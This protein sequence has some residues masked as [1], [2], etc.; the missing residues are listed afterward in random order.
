MT[1]SLQALRQHEMD[2]WVRSQRHPTLPLTIWNY[3]PSCQFQAHWNDVTLAC[4][5]LVTDD[6]GEIVARPVS[7]FFN[8]QEPQSASIIDYSAGFD[9]FT[10]LDGCLCV[11]FNYQGHWVFASRGSF[12]SDHA[13]RMLQ[14][15]MQDHGHFDMLDPALTYCF[16]LIDPE[17]RIVVDYGATSQLVL[18][19]AFDTQT[20][21]E[22]FDILEQMSDIL[23][24]VQR[25]DGLSGQTMS[26]LHDLNVQGEEGFVVR[27]AS[28]ARCKV[29]F[30][31][32]CALHRIVTNLTARSVWQAMVDNGGVLSDQF[33]DS[34]P[35]EFYD[36]VRGVQASLRE[37]FDAIV[38]R[39]TMRVRYL[40]QL[41][42][43]QRGFAQA[44]MSDRDG[45]TTGWLFS[46]DQGR[47]ISDAVW[48]SIRPDATR[49]PSQ[50]VR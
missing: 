46:I 31:D 28:G 4:R 14:I 27:F 33:L 35:D 24:C 23:H 6:A 29:K 45:Y 34:I 2:G 1:I 25:H 47:D 37:Q 9:V 3:T 48:R 44:V 49:P 11:L 19:A 43:D 8:F 16:E 13:E 10:K 5:G 7:K 40:R 50:G 22:V 41:Y 38:H 12:T 32:Y 20:G 18:L 26:M 42:V 30:S 21:D 36:W 39:H 15:W 17:F